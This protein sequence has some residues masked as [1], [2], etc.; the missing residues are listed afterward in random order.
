MEISLAAVRNAASIG[1]TVEEIAAIVGIGRQTLYD[2][3][4]ADPALREALECGRDEGKAT[5]RRWQW[6]AAKK[7][8]KTMLIWLGKQML[9]QRDQQELKH[10]HAH[11]LVPPKLDLWHLTRDQLLQ[12]E[13]TCLVIEASNDAAA[14]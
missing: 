9:G 14:D 8:D 10:D 12:L 6:Q 2:R 11:N 5:L 3:L 1:C 7:G 4:D 13:A